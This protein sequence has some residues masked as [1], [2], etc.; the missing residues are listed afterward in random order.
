MD[1]NALALIALLNLALQMGLVIILAIH[2]LRR[3]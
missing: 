2:L 3:P 1:T